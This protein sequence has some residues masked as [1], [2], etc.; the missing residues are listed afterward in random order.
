MR[1]ASLGTFLAAA[2]TV[3]VLSACAGSQGANAA[4][5]NST[6]QIPTTYGPATSSAHLSGNSLRSLA[7]SVTRIPRDLYVADALANAVDVLHNKSYRELTAI[8]NG[9][10]GPVNVFLDRRGN[11]YVANFNSGS[12]YITEYAPGTTAPSFTYSAGISGPF[13]VAVDAHDN[14]YEGD[15]LSGNVTQYFQKDNYVIASCPVGG[16]AYGVAVDGSNDVFVDYF[17]GPSGPTLIAEYPGGLRGCNEQTLG[18]TSLILP[19]GLALDKNN[20]LLVADGNEVAVVDPPYTS[21]TGT[22]GSGFAEVDNVHLNRD[23]TKA[24][25]TDGFHETVTVVSYPSGANLIV[26]GTQYGL[27]GPV[28]AVDQPNAVY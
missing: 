9:I 7:P 5:P 27:L 13:S 14:V 19:G 28:S 15:V 8:T 18:L 26:L 16:N 11:L 24:F 17:V 1:E 12:G 20:N 6:S 25:V 21:I 22:I 2:S 10:S 23:N 4:L 3:I